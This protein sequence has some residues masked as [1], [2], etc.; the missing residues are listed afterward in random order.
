MH[1]PSRDEGL[2]LGSGQMRRQLVNDGLGQRDRPPASPSPWRPEP[3]H[4]AGLGDDLGDLD[5]VVGRR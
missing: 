2:R 4:S 1:R 5:F 3:H